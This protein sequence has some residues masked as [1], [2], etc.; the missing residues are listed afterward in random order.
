V[1]VK[2][3]IAEG[4]EEDMQQALLGIMVLVDFSLQ[5]GNMSGGWPCRNEL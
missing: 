5:K 4:Y 1:P 3:F 2:R